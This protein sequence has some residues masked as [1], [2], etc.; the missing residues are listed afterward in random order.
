MVQNFHI[1]QSNFNEEKVLH[2]L[3]F[4]HF[5][6]SSLVTRL[7]SQGLGT[8][9]GGL[10]KKHLCNRIFSLYK[11]GNIFLWGYFHS[12]YNSFYNNCRWIS[13]VK[14]NSDNF[15]HNSDLLSSSFPSP[16]YYFFLTRYKW[17]LGDEFLAYVQTLLSC[18]KLH[19]YFRKYLN[20]RKKNGQ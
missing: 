5:H 19:F 18:L 7:Y 8:S 4:Y 6:P 16:R 12:F 17:L 13:E 9:D 14:F 15:E 3:Y 20:V 2:S 10:M 11:I 1:Y